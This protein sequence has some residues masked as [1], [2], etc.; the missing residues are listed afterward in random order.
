MA[1]TTFYNGRTRQQALREQTGETRMSQIK[2]AGF[3]FTFTDGFLL[4][5]PEH[6]MPFPK[7]PK[8]VL[9]EFEA[10]VYFNSPSYPAIVEVR[11][12]PEGADIRGEIEHKRVTVLGRVESRLSRGIDQ[13]WVIADKV[14]TH[15]EIADEAFAIHLSGRGGSAEEDWFR[16]EDALLGIGSR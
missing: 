14:V 2:I 5:V 16:A 7:E 6:Q 15:S 10:E 8:K 12:D 3:F 1:R 13:P 9:A 4:L 11:I